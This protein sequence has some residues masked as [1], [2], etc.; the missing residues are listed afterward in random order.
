MFAELDWSLLCRWG[1]GEVSQQYKLNK[2]TATSILQH[3]ELFNM[4]VSAQ[5][6][7]LE[8]VTVRCAGHGHQ[9]ARDGP[10]GPAAG[11]YS[12]PTASTYTC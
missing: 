11:S 6:R 7:T 8:P 12:P 10:A 9:G 2:Q 5:L 1:A 4:M 3:Y